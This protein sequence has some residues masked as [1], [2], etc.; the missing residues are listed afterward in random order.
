MLFL[1]P[2]PFASYF[3]LSSF[4]F[5]GAVGPAHV[6]EPDKHELIERQ[7]GILERSRT[8]VDQHCDAAA[9]HE[10]SG[11]A[12]LVSHRERLSCPNT[13]KSE[14]VARGKHTIG[15]EAQ[16]YKT[17]A[18]QRIMMPHVY[19]LW[20]NVASDSKKEVKNKQVAKRRRTRNPNYSE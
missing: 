10:L 9:S 19:V 7:A 18:P 8:L 16:A 20:R 15:L 3:F 13:D 11:I 4:F 1:Q 5:D 17:M 6:H 12:R 2:L 14:R